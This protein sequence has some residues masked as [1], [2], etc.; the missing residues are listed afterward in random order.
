MPHSPKRSLTSALFAS[1][2]LSCYRLPDNSPFC[3]GRVDSAAK[4]TCSRGSSV[5]LR[6]TVGAPRLEERTDAAASENS[7]SRLPARARCHPSCFGPLT[8]RAR[9]RLTRR[10]SVVKGLTASHPVSF[11]RAST[12]FQRVLLRGKRKAPS[13]SISHELGD[14]LASRVLR[15]LARYRFLEKLLRSVTIEGMPR[16]SES[17]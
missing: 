16:S 15:T 12:A 17:E 9:S 13:R 2:Y 7:Y 6:C 5:G 14:F 10:R 1:R 3:S 11:G 8:A 4:A